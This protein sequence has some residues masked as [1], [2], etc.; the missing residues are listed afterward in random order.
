MFAHRLQVGGTVSAKVVMD[1]NGPG[2]SLPAG[3]IVQAH[4]TALTPRSK[5]SKGSDV[6]LS[7][8]AATC[9]KVALKPYSL[10]MVV[11]AA[12]FEDPDAVETAMPRSIAGGL[13]SET[14]DDAQAAHDMRYWALVRPDL[15]SGRVYGI[16]GLSL[17]VGPANNSVLS[18]TRHDVTLFQHT[19]LLLVPRSEIVTNA[20]K[21]A[22]VPH[23]QP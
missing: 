13:R 3:S 4:V 20:A 1:W 23:S 5:T 22:D 19:Q 14:S 11:V 9:G 10:I 7:F 16:G 21:N 18:S 12:P 6:A 15:E 8:D 2:C 17:S